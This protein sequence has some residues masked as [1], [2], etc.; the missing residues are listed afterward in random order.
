MRETIKVIKEECNS[1][2]FLHCNPSRTIC[3]S[4]FTYRNKSAD[5]LSNV[6]NMK[7]SRGQIILSNVF[8][9]TYAVSISGGDV[10]VIEALGE[11]N[12]EIGDILDGNLKD[13]GE[14]YLWNEKSGAVQVFVK[15]VNFS[16]DEALECLGFK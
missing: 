7:I 15:K 11:F 1:S 9:M 6:E 12:L 3:G 13:L 10:T 8:H 2:G 4:I 5:R 16:I 14:Q